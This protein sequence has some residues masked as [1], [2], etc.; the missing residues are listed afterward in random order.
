MFDSEKWYHAS[1][2]DVLRLASYFT[3]AHWRSEGRGP[4]Y[5]KIGNRVVYRGLDLNAW[6]AG[7]RVATEVAP[8]STAEAAGAPA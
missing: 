6:I 2:P 8:I 1:D 4:A 5:H 7:R 3:M